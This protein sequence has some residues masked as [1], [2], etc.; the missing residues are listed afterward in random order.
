MDGAILI[1]LP[2]FLRG[3]K[4]PQFSRDHRNPD[5]LVSS[6]E[7]AEDSVD[8]ACATGNLLMI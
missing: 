3:I 1:C 6:T 7:N 2:K 8:S 4:R 5:S